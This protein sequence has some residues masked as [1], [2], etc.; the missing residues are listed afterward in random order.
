MTDTPDTRPLLLGLN[1]PLSDSPKMALWP[2]PTNCTGWRIWR[3]VGCS[4]EDYIRGFDRRNLLDATHYSR[5]AVRHYRE[6][7][8]KLAGRRVL[9]LGVQVL[10][11]LLYAGV[12][13]RRPPWILPQ[14]GD[15]PL[16]WRLIPHPSGLCREYN[17][18][19]MSIRVSLLLQDWWHNHSGRSDMRE[20]G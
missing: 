3:M 19:S 7:W 17:D 4:K 1:N 11:E 20:V 13:S 6:I 18:P 2:E 8:E 16:E 15:G 12:V 14:K 10:G 9:V 5:Q